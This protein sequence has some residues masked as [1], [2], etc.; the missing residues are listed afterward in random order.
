MTAATLM[1]GWLVLGQTSTLPVPVAA[2]SSRRFVQPPA[3]IVASPSDDATTP[4]IDDGMRSV[5]AVGEGAGDEIVGATKRTEAVQRRAT[6]F[7]AADP[8]AADRRADEI[9][10]CSGRTRIR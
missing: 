6:D 7:R 3:T 10:Q 9:A 5:L 8:A 1:L 4:P 2:P